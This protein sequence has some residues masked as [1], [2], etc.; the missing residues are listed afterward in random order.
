[1]AFPDGV[2]TTEEEVVLH[3]HPHGRTAVRP[4]LVLVVAIALI[5]VAWVM[6]PTNPGGRIGVLVIGAAALLFALV[7]GVWPLVVWRCTHYVL[8]N[9]RILLQDGVLARV[10]RDLPL[11]RVNDHAMSQSLL[12][13]MFRSGTLTID[14]LGER[15]PAVLAAVPRVEQVQ[16]TLYELIEAD[17]EAHDGEADDEPAPPERPGPWGRRRR[18]S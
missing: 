6:L 14:S 5:T 11:A 7:K 17:R 8:T 18:V 9:E 13:R 16:T 2:L 1:V 4:V 3:L 10:R 15:G 12:D